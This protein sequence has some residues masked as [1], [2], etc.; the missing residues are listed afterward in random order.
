M[1]SLGITA[2]FCVTATAQQPEQTTPV[3]MGILLDTSG[4]MGTKLP[5]ARQLVSE[6]LKQASSQ[7][8][9]ALIQ[10]AERPVVLTGFGSPADVFEA[11]VA[12]T[13][14]RGRSALLNIAP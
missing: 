12:F 1:I 14:P 7:D 10:A 5:R 4:S 13:Q 11:Q 3:S 6:F 2:L 8:E 9:L